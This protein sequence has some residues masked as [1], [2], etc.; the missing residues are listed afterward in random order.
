MSNFNIKKFLIENKITKYSRLSEGSRFRDNEVITGAT[1]EFEHNGDVI[2]WTGDYE[3]TTSGETA[4]YD[5]P[6]DSETE[7][8]I[9]HTSDL[10]RYNEETD[11]YEQIEETPELLDIIADLLKNK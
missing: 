5:Y 9:L 3:I 2:V 4:D 1:E 11:T 8:E 10:A 6:G 7:V